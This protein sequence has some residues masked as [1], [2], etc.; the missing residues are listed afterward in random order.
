MDSE[1]QSADHKLRSQ[2]MNERAAEAQRGPKTIRFKGHT[3]TI[4]ATKTTFTTGEVFRPDW[5]DLKA[6]TR[7]LVDLGIAEDLVPNASVI[8]QGANRGQIDA[9]VPDLLAR[10]AFRDYA[11]VAPFQVRACLWVLACYW[12]IHLNGPRPAMP[13]PTRQ[14]RLQQVTMRCPYCLEKFKAPQVA[15]NQG[16]LIR[17]FS[18]W[19]YQHSRDHAHKDVDTSTRHIEEE[20]V[21][22]T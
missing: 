20:L 15:A 9:L 10:A 22:G 5:D 7:R 13:K 1:D 6:V 4:G 11:H 18:K 14:P 19:M 12:H 17:M 16:Y 3:V 8:L 21:T 2:V